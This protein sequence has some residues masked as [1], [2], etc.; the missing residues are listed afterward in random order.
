MEMSARKHLGKNMSEIKRTPA[1]RENRTQEAVDH[2]RAQLRSLRE[3]RNLTRKKLAELANISLTSLENYE[4]GHHMPS[5]EAILT[6][7]ST[8]DVSP[9]RL[10]GWNIIS[11][12]CTEH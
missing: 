2:F 3:E 7:C 4:Y 9:N 8:L 12:H 1:S 10:L 6:L 11:E 5:F